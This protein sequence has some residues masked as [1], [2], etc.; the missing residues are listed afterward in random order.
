MDPITLMAV[1]AYILLRNQK[2][3]NNPPPSSPMPMR[4]DRG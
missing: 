2:G 1:A 4:L 3:G